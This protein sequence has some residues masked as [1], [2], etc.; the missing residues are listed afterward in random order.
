MILYTPKLEDLWFRKQFMAEEETMSYNHHW[1]GTIPFPEENWPDWY[2]YW[3]A[4]PEGKRFYRYLQEETSGEFIGEIAYHF[5]AEEQ[6][7]IADVIVHAKYRGKGFGEQGLRMLCKAAKE[8][9]VVVLY[10][11]IAID[12][13]AIKLFLKCGFYE[14]YRTD[15]I[16]ML[17]KDLFV[18]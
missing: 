13:S 1:G 4:N 10:D 18:N 14:E 6:K 11:N 12:N 9:G 15:E 2:D 16:I 7:Y 8:R 17:R 3:V 5:D